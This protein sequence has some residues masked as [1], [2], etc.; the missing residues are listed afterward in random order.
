MRRG[1]AYYKQAKEAK[2]LKAWQRKQLLASK[3]EI[4]TRMAATKGGKQS[5]EKTL[6]LTPMLFGA[7]KIHAQSLGGW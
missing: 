2:K 3:L 4:P 7:T 1:T 6:L 5:P